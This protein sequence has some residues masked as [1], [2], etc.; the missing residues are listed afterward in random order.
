M[1]PVSRTRIAQRLG[2]SAPTVLRVVEQLLD[3]RLIRFGQ[4]QNQSSAG[5]PSTLLEF[6]GTAHAAIAVSI[7]VRVTSAMLVDLCGNV[8]E[9]RQI[10]QEAENGESVLRSVVVAV[11]EV[12]QVARSLETE[13]RGIV[14][15]IPG[16]VQNPGG[17]VRDAPG[18]D[19]WVDRDIRGELQERFGLAV[20]VENDVNLNALG[21]LGF[22]AARGYDTSVSFIVGRGLG[23]GI[24]LNG[25]LYHGTHFAAGEVGYMPS[26]TNA[27]G[28]EHGDIGRI[29]NFT[30]GEGLE[31]GLMELLRSKRVPVDVGEMTPEVLF[32]NARAGESWAVAVVEEMSR[33]LALAVSNVL[34]LIDPEIVVIGGDVGAEFGKTLIEIADPIIRRQVP[35]VPPIVASGLGSLATAMGAI[36]LIIHGTT[37]QVRV[38]LPGW[39]EDPQP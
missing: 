32:A 16:I 11:E 18:L 10:F 36:M 7:G 1:G 33:Y 27:V 28:R 22:G 24:I 6:N 9:L 34:V 35:F 39:S 29:F 30:M 5:R 17:H 26:D 37:N 21:E 23:A 3:E 15:G 8:R 31:Y 19:D 25:S 4:K 14:V 2:M 12:L 20:F 38:S 13:L